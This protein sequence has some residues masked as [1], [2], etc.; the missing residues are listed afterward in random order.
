MTRA[1][2]LRPCE[3]APQLLTPSETQNN[4]ELCVGAYLLSPAETLSTIGSRRLNCRVRNEIGCIPSDEA[5]TQSPQ[6]TLDEY[7][8]ICE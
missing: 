2:A 8:K 4:C 1:V 3:A 5:P 6:W 7:A